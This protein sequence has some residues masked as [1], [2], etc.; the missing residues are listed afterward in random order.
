MQICEQHEQLGNSLILSNPG[1][2]V[3]QPIYDSGTF[4]TIN[5]SQVKSLQ[6]YL[7]KPED[8]YD[9]YDHIR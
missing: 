3:Y 1:F 9:T 2:T 5:K 8:T 7:N 6:V 4:C